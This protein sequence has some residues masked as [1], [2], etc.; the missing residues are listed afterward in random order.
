MAID[1]AG[2]VTI[3]RS[4]LAMLPVHQ[5]G[6]HAKD[7]MIRCP[8]CGDSKKDP[9]HA[10][11]GI[12]M[13]PTSR[14]GKITF[15][16]R[17]F[18]CNAHAGGMSVDVAKKIGI[19]SDELLSYLA[20]VNKQIASSFQR[21][22]S[23]VIAKKFEYSKP[24]NLIED[25]SFKKDYLW[26]RL[27]CE[28]LCDNP[29][30]FKLVLDLRQFFMKNK[31]KPNPDYGKGVQSMLRSLHNNGIGFVS[32]D[33][34]HINFRDIR[35]HPDQRYTQYLI[36]PDWMMKRNGID[37]ETSSAY[38]VPTNVN[39]MAPYLK[40]VMAEGSFDI[41]RIYT[42]FY[43]CKPDPGLIFASVSNS[44]GYAP[45]IT[46][47]LEYGI[48]FDEIEIFSDND[49][50]LSHYKNSVKPIAP[51]S[52]FIVH[53]NRLAKDVGDVRD[54]LKLSTITI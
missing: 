29:D 25:M 8:F 4:E 17:C 49:V 44:H 42:D 53:Y 26:N 32:F 34:T 6:P 39:T 20:N 30:K 13:V 10:H 12:S 2:A 3:M 14:H 24:E 41:L 35:P 40:L 11:F 19:Q 1:S 43:G 48:M 45:M 37:V 16:Y 7:V 50:D 51:D 5:G 38:V 31:L 15:A 47:Y 9:K 36:Y 46:K 22:G 18:L 23:N 21:S 54:P 52:K 33:N 27:R 28:E